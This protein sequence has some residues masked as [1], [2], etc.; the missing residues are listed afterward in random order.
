MDEIIEKIANEILDVCGS[1]DEVS[2]LIDNILLYIADLVCEDEW[3]PE[4]K[5]I[6]QSIKD[7]RDDDRLEDDAVSEPDLE[8]VVDE[9]GFES[10][11]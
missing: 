8:V 1:E 3:S 4:P 6:K 10:L 9:E 11:R 2:A 5:D 7:L